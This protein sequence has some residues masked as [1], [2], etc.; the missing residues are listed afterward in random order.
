[1]FYPESERSQEQE[2]SRFFN[3][4]G[5]SPDF[6][7]FQ[8]NICWPWPHATNDDGYGYQQ[9]RGKVQ[10]AHRLIWSLYND[11]EI[12][13]GMEITHSCDT[14]RCV[15]PRHLVLATHKANMRDKCLKGR[16]RNGYTAKTLGYVSEGR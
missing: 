7:E 11:C 2:K 15:N 3:R 8:Q 5:C 4:V 1:M 13:A 6:K 12:P 10:R 16:H 14:P 9:F